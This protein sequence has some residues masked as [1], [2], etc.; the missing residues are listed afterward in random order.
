MGKQIKAGVIK[1]GAIAAILYVI[2]VTVTFQ[3]TQVSE[4]AERASL[5]YDLDRGT[6]QQ[7]Q[8]LS[9]ARDDAQ[10]ERKLDD[11]NAKRRA[12]GKRP[13]S[14]PPSV[15]SD[16]GSMWEKIKGAEVHCAAL[17]VRIDRLTGA[18]DFRRRSTM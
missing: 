9:A 10:A 1:A 14:L 11:I 7:Q 5:Q 8:Y 3:R 16:F 4:A 13:L 12:A 18:R 2:A 17:K 15:S 6:A